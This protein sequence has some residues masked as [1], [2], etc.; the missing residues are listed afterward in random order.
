MELER[1]AL[2]GLGLSYT[3]GTAE[4]QRIGV[5]AHLSGRRDLVSYDPEDPDR[6]LHTVALDETEAR[7]VAQLLDLPIVVDQVTELTGGLDGV[8][9]V[10]IPIAAGSP[11]C[12]RRLADTRARTRT[13]ASIVAVVRDGHAIPS[14][15]PDFEF[16]GGDRVVAVGDAAAVTG[17]REVLING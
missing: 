10:R 13:G 12:G 2:P 5:V 16:R 7:T 3:F 15:T 11:Y 14:P 4:G 17:L 8:Q 9:T 1:T 6:V